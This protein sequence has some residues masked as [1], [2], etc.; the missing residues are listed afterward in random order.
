MSLHL[1]ALHCVALARSFLLSERVSFVLLG[2]V[3]HGAWSL[4]LLPGHFVPFSFLRVRLCL[5]LCSMYVGAVEAV[6]AMLGVR[7]SPKSKLL[8]MC[9]QMGVVIELQPGGEII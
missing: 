3:Q 1:I 8:H 5:C 7:M 4:L 2:R 9:R 6:G